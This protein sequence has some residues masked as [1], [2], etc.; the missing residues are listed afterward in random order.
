MQKINFLKKIKLK[1]FSRANRNKIRSTGFDLNLKQKTSYFFLRD[2][3]PGCSLIDQGGIEILNI[4]LALEKYKWLKNYYGKLIKSKNPSQ[5][6]FVRSLA[7]QKIDNPVQLCLYI[8]ANQLQQNLH[9][10]IIAEKNSRLNI[11]TGCLTANSV[12]E[13]KHIGITEIYL[14]EGAQVIYNMIH[15]WEKGVIVRAR[16]ATQV[17]ENASLVSNYLCLAPVKDLQISPVC[18]LEG[19]NSRAKYNSLVYAHPNSK[20]DIGTEVFLNGKGTKSEVTNKSISNEGII[21]ARGHLIGAAPKIKA[22][23]DCKGL[24][25][26]KKGNIHALPELE[27]Q[28]SEVEMTHEAAVG[29]ISQEAIEYLMARGLSR[30]KAISVI[31]RGFADISTMVLPKRIQ[32][33]I[34]GFNIGE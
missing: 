12:A 10:I 25:V 20:L 22:H 9:N 15:N 30:K 14:K 32:K 2:M 6:Y 24:I 11:I 1:Y 18:Y 16:A 21:Y 34:E 7:G 31:I 4:N 28:L 27:A 8:A 29:K 3:N 17:G 33:E 13:A 5:G 19:K 26:S 23:L